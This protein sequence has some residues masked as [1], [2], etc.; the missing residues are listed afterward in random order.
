MFT[1]GTV[2]MATLLRSRHP[3]WLMDNLNWVELQNAIGDD[4]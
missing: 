1:R 2:Q 3:N 4:D